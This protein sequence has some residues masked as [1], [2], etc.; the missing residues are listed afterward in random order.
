MSQS[1]A[2]RHGRIP[3]YFTAVVL[4]LLAV[5]AVAGAQGGTAKPPKGTVPV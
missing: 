2:S 5:A 3:V 1:R 4:A